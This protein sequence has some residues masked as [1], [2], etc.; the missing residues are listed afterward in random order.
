MPITS[1]NSNSLHVIILREMWGEFFTIQLD[2]GHT[3]E[4]Y[5][6]EIRKWFKDRGAN[7]ESTEKVL[8]QAWNFGAAKATFENYKEP[9]STRLPH[10]PNI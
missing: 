8:D 2:N 6:E 1:G 3:E 4:L 9:K 10:S 5:P 7:E